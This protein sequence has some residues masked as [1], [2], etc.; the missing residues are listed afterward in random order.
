MLN[1]G[2]YGPCKSVAEQAERVSSMEG[3]YCCTTLERGCYLASQSMYYRQERGYK[4]NDDIQ[5]VVNHFHRTIHTVLVLNF[6][7]SVSFYLGEIIVLRFYSWLL[8]KQI[9]VAMLNCSS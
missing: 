3:P 6:S 1:I 7:I 9:K 2:A 5:Q 4:S 8:Y